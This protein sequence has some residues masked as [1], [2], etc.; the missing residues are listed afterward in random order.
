[1]IVSTFGLQA[2]SSDTTK[3]LYV[4]RVRALRINSREQFHGFKSTCSHQSSFNMLNSK[5]AENGIRVAFS[6]LQDA[7]K[8]KPWTLKNRA[9]IQAKPGFWTLL[10]Q[11][12]PRCL[13]DTP[14]FMLTFVLYTFLHIKVARGQ[15]AKFAQATKVP[16]VCHVR[17]FSNYFS[18]EF[19]VDIR[20][21]LVFTYQ[22]GPRTVLG[23]QVKYQFN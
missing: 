14:N 6:C 19:Y 22:S 2:S 4:L 11:Q 13:Q 16:Y 12:P 1:M 8:A 18:Y 21:V 3:V 23:Q 5:N 7:P 17:P 10:G 20:F 15:S 9:R